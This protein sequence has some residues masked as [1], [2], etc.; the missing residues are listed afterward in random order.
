MS[1]NIYHS[2]I[3]PENFVLDK[4][5][6]WK[7]MSVKVIDF[8]ISTINKHHKLKGLTD[9]Y[10]PKDIA[11]KV[12]SDNRPKIIFASKQE[13]ERYKIYQIGRTFQRIMLDSTAKYL[14]TQCD[15]V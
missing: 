3:K 9:D 10:V 11:V 14:K 1:K 12:K 8:G 5:S 7:T 6:S 15:Y 2:D 13:R 4:T